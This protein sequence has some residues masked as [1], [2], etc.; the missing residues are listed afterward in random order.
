MMPKVDFQIRIVFVQMTLVLTKAKF[1]ACLKLAVPFTLLL[2]C[3]IGQVDQ[4][5]A[6]LVATVHLT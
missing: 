5:V 3:I 4:A 2:H 6:K 1:V